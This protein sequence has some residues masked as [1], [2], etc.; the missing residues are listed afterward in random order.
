[1]SID[2]ASIQAG[3]TTQTSVSASQISVDALAAND[4]VSVDSGVL[5]GQSPTVATGVVQDYLFQSG[6]LLGANGLGTWTDI[7][8]ADS[9]AQDKSGAVFFT[10]GSLLLQATGAA[11]WTSVTTVQGLYQGNNT[12]GQPVVYICQGGALQQYSGGATPASGHWTYIG[13]ADS[14]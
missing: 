7:G 10:E 5:G 6:R 13:G 1:I 11:G 14:V 12:A 4:L 2:G 8:G 3:A 9:V